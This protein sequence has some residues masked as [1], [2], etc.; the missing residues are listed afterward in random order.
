M[1]DEPF[2]MAHLQAKLANGYFDYK[3]KE[4]KKELSVKDLPD[5]GADTSD[6]LPLITKQTKPLGAKA[7]IEKRRAQLA[8]E[9]EE[10][11]EQI[12]KAAR[13]KILQIK[14]RQA[15]EKASPTSA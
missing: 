5:V 6:V 3:E 7:L 4:E 11:K 1:D 13:E 15:K 10:A 8:K 14:A 9:K 12:K 2:F